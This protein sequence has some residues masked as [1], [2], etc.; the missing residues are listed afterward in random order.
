MATKSCA[1]LKNG[2]SPLWRVWALTCSL[3]LSHIRHQTQSVS[4]GKSIGMTSESVLPFF[5]L[6]VE[7]TIKGAKALADTLGFHDGSKNAAKFTAWSHYPRHLS[8]ATESTSLGV[9]HGRVKDSL[10]LLA[11]LAV[12]PS[13]CSCLLL[14]VSGWPFVGRL[15]RMAYILYIINI[16]SVWMFCLIKSYKQGCQI[17]KGMGRIHHTEQH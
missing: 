10:T 6:E 14:A 3:Q 2:L 16:T 8:F 4:L 11:C 5:L 7:S 15:R 17:C 9:A 13:A 1:T 12:R